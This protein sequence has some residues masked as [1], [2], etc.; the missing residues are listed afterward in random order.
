MLKFGVDYGSLLSVWLLTMSSFSSVSWRKTYPSIS[1]HAKL[2]GPVL[3]LLVLSK[4]H[5][6]S[7]IS[8]LVSQ[9]HHCYLQG[10]LNYVPK[11]FYICGLRSSLWH[12]RDWH[13]PSLPVTWHGSPCPVDT[14]INLQGYGS[15]KYF[16]LSTTS[17]LFGCCM[18]GAIIF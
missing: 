17:Y 8:C 15:Q 13:W 18:T 3:F 7:L 10:L 5:F 14:M 11:L 4:C 6:E 9:H 16:G 1:M 12:L 2:E